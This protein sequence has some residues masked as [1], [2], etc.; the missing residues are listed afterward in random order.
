MS[1]DA[2]GR[3]KSSN[4]KT[5]DLN[6]P[7]PR[8]WTPEDLSG[9]LRV[10]KHWV[11]KR[12]SARSEDSPPRCPGITQIRFDTHNPQFQEWL[13][14]QLGYTYPVEDDQ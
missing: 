13:A 5:I 12:T 8:I 2:T 7:G 14:R 11:Y 3:N 9:F 4:R 10:S 6:L 1:E